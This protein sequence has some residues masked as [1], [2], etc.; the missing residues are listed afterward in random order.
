MRNSVLLLAL[1][2]AV[3]VGVAGMAGA[4]H[5]FR[6]V[7]HTSVHAPGIHWADEH[8]IIEGFG[9]GTF[10]P[11]ATI[12]RD[13]VASMLHRYD[14]H[15]DRKI[16]AALADVEPERDALEPLPPF[17]RSSVILDP[18][19]VHVPKPVYV[20]DTPD[21][22]QQGL[23]GV[24]ELPQE[25]G[26]LFMFPD[27]RTGGFWMRDTLIPLS[28]AFLAEDG[29]VLAILDMDPCEADPCP[30]HDP[31]VAYRAALEVNQGR[32]AD[33]GLGEPGWRVAIPATLGPGT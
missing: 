30:V 7:P 16:A 3:L 31:G 20:A 32:F 18:D 15:V 9:D 17:S 22:R 1:A 14:R 21:L 10:Q 27:D 28:I 12:L 25:A 2:A 33:L 5:V 13:Q 4:T 6:D 24:E 23:M 26:M 29:T 11:R 8:G 19:G